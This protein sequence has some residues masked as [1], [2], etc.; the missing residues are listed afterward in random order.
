MKPEDNASR[1]ESCG[2]CH[3]RQETVEQ[4]QRAH[5]QI[6]HHCGRW[7]PEDCGAPRHQ[8]SA[9][10]PDPRPEVAVSRG[11]GSRQL[12][13]DRANL[14]LR[15]RAAAASIAARLISSFVAEGWSAETRP[16]DGTELLRSALGPCH[17]GRVRASAVT[18]GHRRC[19]G[20]A[21]RRPSSSR[22]W[23]DAGG[24]F[25]LWSRR[26]G[27]RVPSVTQLPSRP[28]ALHLLHLRA[29]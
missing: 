10:Q 19:R 27:V 18:S 23:D 6:A 4:S 17:N 3:G 29:A 9:S 12:R 7:H 15:V 24:R 13:W 16:T 28:F 14:V 11:G 1:Q 26:A 5:P 20:T 25:G 2:G 8:A 22:S 21:G